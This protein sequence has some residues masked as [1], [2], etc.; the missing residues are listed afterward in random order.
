[1][2][3]FLRGKY[4]LVGVTGGIAAY[5]SVDL[6]RKLREFGAITKV[7]MTQ[8]AKKFVTPL[9]FQAISGQPVADELFD[10]AAEAAMGHIELARWADVILIAPTTANFMAKLASGYADDL[11]SSIC[12]ASRAPT[13]IA[14]AMNQAMW[15]HPQTQNNLT[16]LI[17][18]KIHVF[19]PGI[20][21]QACGE[22][23]PGRMLEPI[24]IIEQLNTLFPNKQLTGK[25]VVITAGP[26]REYIDAV[27]YISNPSSGQMGY[28][29]AT[30]AIEM[31]AKVTLISGPV[32]LQ[33]PESA[34]VINV[35]SATEM[36]QAS[37]TQLADCN[38]FIGVAAVSDYRPSQ[39]FNNKIPKQD[40]ELNIQLTPN[41]DIIAEVARTKHRPFVVGFAAESD[42][43]VEKARA[44][45]LAKKLDMIIG[46]LIGPQSG[47]EQ[48]DNEVVI[49][50]SNYEQHLPRMAKTQLARQLITLIA[51]EANNHGRSNRNTKNNKQH[52]PTQI[53]PS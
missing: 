12:L 2:H 41:P 7:V 50:T 5:K 19:G 10:L 47:F 21:S 28:A 1:M 42:Q 11:L 43:L 24:E 13:A 22:T 29:L 26:T 38:I 6:I 49:L 31:G 3:E 17:Q 25:H 23:G 15:Q 34:T 8:N 44:K 27:R 35:T 9:T 45:L 30:A 39:Q 18:Q 46:N 53:S 4:I 33:P 51:E 40:L 32:T 14:P 16:K 36:H 37:M 48:P 20:G 52:E